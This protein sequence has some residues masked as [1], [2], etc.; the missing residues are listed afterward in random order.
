[1]TW[2]Y[3]AAHSPTEPTDQLVMQIAEL[4]TREGVLDPDD[5][6]ELDGV[7]AEATA[8]VRVGGQRFRIG[9]QRW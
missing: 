7:G 3:S 5:P 8:L 9:V 6:V 4:L 1:M 2:T